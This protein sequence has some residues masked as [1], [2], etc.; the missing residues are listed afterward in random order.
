MV[1]SP[2][3]R[4]HRRD[5][6]P[7]PRAGADGR[8]MGKLHSPPF[9][10]PRLPPTPQSFPSPRPGTPA[11]PRRRVRTS[12]ARGRPPSRAGCPCP[13]RGLA[14]PR[15]PGAAA[16]APALPPAQPGGAAAS[17]RRLRRG[18]AAVT[19]GAGGAAA[20]TRPRLRA[21]SH[22]ASGSACSSPRGRL[23]RDSYSWSALTD[24]SAAV[25]IPEPESSP[26]RRPFSVHLGDCSGSVK[27]LLHV[28][29]G[30]PL[31]SLLPDAAT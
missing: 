5:P 15:G 11:P 9:R 12:C 24:S 16:R 13:A 7:A 30:I 25:I 4:G 26:V 31:R 29:A 2:K 17:E 18:R 8:N 23:V 28:T 6:P 19:P 22:A 20:G 27:N 14:Q 21:A 3:Q 1:R 10:W